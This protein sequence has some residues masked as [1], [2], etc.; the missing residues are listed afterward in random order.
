MTT[1]LKSYLHVRKTTRQELRISGQRMRD[2]RIVDDAAALK[3]KPDAVPD[4][5]KISTGPA[6]CSDHGAMG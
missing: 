2:N 3:L 1:F 5:F 6:V 4:I